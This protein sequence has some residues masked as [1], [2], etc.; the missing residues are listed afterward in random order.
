MDDR[1]E[2][3]DV[4]NRAKPRFDDPSIRPQH[5]AW[6]SL[7]KPL[8]LVE[9]TALL[10]APNEFARDY[11]DNRL[12]PIIASVLS[13]ELGRDIR[14][15]VTVA[16]PDEQMAAEDVPPEDDEA[17]PPED[18]GWS[19]EPSRHQIPGPS[20]RARHAEGPIRRVHPI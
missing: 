19:D 18:D 4:W 17:F 8:G 5:K 2:L 12:R 20:Y 15:A 7:T 13:E 1:S 16:H 11:L 14:V 10:A 6:I 9:D 3:I